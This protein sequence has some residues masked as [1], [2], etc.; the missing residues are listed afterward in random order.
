MRQAAEVDIPVFAHCED[1][2]LAA[3]GVMNAGGREPRNLAFSE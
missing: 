2:N 1:T 3:R